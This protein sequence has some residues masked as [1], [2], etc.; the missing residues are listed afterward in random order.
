[1]S[2]GHARIGGRLQGGPGSARHGARLLHL[3][4]RRRLPARGVAPAGL[5]GG[6]PVLRGGAGHLPEVRGLRPV[7]VSVRAVLVLPVPA[8]GRR[9][10]GSGALPQRH[11]VRDGPEPARASDRGHRMSGPRRAGPDG[12]EAEPPVRRVRRVVRVR[13]QRE[14]V[15]VRGGRARGPPHPHRPGTVPAFFYFLLFG[16]SVSSFLVILCCFPQKH[17]AR[18]RPGSSAT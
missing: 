3:E 6:S 12:D 9:P 11:P 13:G 5:R 8:S 18:W 10:G 1:M 17:R 7:P 16:F 2:P 4:H 15:P 14:S